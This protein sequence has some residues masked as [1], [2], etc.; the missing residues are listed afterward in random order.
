[1]IVFGKRSIRARKV[2][3]GMLGMA[4][5]RENFAIFACEIAQAYVR[6]KTAVHIEPIRALSPAFYC[7]TFTDLCSPLNCTA[8]AARIPPSVF[9]SPALRQAGMGRPSRRK[10]AQTCD[11]PRRR[12]TSPV[13]PLG[14]F[15]AIRA[16]GETSPTGR[17]ALLANWLFSSRHRVRLCFAVLEQDGPGSYPFARG[18]PSEMSNITPQ[19]QRHLT[20]TSVSG[21]MSTSSNS[22]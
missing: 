13:A 19:L 16:A 6:I 15:A 10:A 11:G 21:I 9:P 5:K 8:G 3:S 18:F 17:L 4:K 20:A 1:M 22:Q 14:P 7:S 12:M 2:V